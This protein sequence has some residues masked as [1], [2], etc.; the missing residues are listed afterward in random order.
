M[1]FLWFSRGSPLSEL[2]SAGILDAKEP[3]RRPRWNSSRTR[4][5]GHGGSWMFKGYQGVWRGIW[6]MIFVQARDDALMPRRLGYVL[7]EGLSHWCQSPAV[8]NKN[9]WRM[10]HLQCPFEV[11]Y[12]PTSQNR[13]SSPAWAPWWVSLICL[14]CL[15]CLT[16]QHFCHPISWVP[17]TR[18]AM[19]K[20][21]IK[22]TMSSG[23]LG[24]S[25]GTSGT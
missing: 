21:A 6:P 18:L 8:P 10:F 17:L 4:R 15:L 19:V 20:K 2:P 12:F 22:T 11:I 16:S 9:D 7:L 13:V 25:L 24:K 3:P 5:D 14:L 23:F 1:V